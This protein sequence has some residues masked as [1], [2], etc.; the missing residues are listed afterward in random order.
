MG[1]KQGLEILIEGARAVKDPRVQFVLCGE[2]NRKEALQEL[3]RKYQLA[4]VRFFPLQPDIHYRELLVDA[5]I[6]VITQQKGSSNFFFPSKLLNTLAFAKPVLT[7]ADES[8]ELAR[9]LR[10]GRF[11]VNVEPSNP[12]AIAEAIQRMICDPQLLTALGLAGRAYV[13]RFE[14]KIVLQ[15]FHQEVLRSLDSERTEQR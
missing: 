14:M 5:N 12:L 1:A 11:G 4:N 3:S 2:G 8:S 10:E 7:V 6:C 15:R 9:A 13:E